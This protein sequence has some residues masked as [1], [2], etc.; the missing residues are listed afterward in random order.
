MPIH[1]VKVER[2]LPMHLKSEVNMTYTM[3]IKYNFCFI[4][5]NASYFESS[6]MCYLL[7]IY[8]Y[9]QAYIWTICSNYWS[10][11]KQGRFDTD[12]SWNNRTWIW[13]WHYGKNFLEWYS[14]FSVRIMKKGKLNY[15]SVNYNY[16]CILYSLGSMS[17]KN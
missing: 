11:R 14:N 2:G 10:V 1:I 5:R 7:S 9:Y 17:N 12:R 3:P 8:V 4:Y 13:S 16:I 6:T 15:V